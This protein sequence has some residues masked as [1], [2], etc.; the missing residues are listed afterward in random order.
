MSW[1]LH[2]MEI[3]G[4]KRVYIGFFIEAI[5]GS[6]IIFVFGVLIDGLSV[7]DDSL[8][9]PLIC[10][11]HHDDMMQTVVIGLASNLVY[12]SLFQITM[13]TC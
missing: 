11:L 1:N 13:N 3:S 8:L 6:K 9:T 10:C 2:S 7:L 4:N 12:Y 5:D